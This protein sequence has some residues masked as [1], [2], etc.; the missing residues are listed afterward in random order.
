[1]AP[2]CQGVTKALSGVKGT[3]VHW[4]KMEDC[5]PF[6]PS[7]EVPS[8][9]PPSVEREETTPLLRS[10]DKAQGLTRLSC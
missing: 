10:W 3:L 1:M 8:K 7:K 4:K 2:P 6:S 9:P 5:S